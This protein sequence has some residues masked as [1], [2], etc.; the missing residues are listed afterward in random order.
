VLQADQEVVLL[1][2]RVYLFRLNIEC[3]NYAEQELEHVWVH[4][5]FK[6][7]TNPDF[8]E[9]FESSRPWYS[10]SQAMLK[11]IKKS[12]QTPDPIKGLHFN[13]IL[14]KT[15]QRFIGDPCADYEHKLRINGKYA[16][17]FAYIEECLLTGLHLPEL[18]AVMNVTPTHLSFMFRK[19]TGQTLKHY[20]TRQLLSRASHELLYT[21]RP[22]KEIARDLGFDYE[23]YFSR[24]FKKFMHCTPTEFRR[25]TITSR[26]R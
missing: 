7:G 16:K 18:A 3:K 25:R 14:Q 13:T 17:L 6:C 8:F 20:I 15:I 11:Y 2:G 26:S 9:L 21:D 12:S 10:C 4:F 22:I 23:I 1:P 24:L 19:D 5:K